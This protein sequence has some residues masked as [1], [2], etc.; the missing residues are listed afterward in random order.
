MSLTPLSRRVAFDRPWRGITLVLALTVR[1]SGAVAQLPTGCAPRRPR[2]RRRSTLGASIALDR[3]GAL[4]RAAER[5][6]EFIER[7]GLRSPV[8]VVFNGTRIAFPLGSSKALDGKR[9]LVASLL[10]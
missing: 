10:S 4:A 7:A 2:A 5:T 8:P 1:V 6:E 9:S 3:F